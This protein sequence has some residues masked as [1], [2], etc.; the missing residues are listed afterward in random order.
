M[1]Q[2]ENFAAPVGRVLIA[3]IFVMSG[4]FKIVNYSETA[5]WMAHMGV[6][7]AYLLDNRNVA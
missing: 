5:G 2:L 7:G 4:I 1:T 3:L 6:P